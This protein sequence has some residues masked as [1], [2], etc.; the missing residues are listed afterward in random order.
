ME[1]IWQNYDI[2]ICAKYFEIPFLHEKITLK[3]WKAWVKRE[4]EPQNPLNLDLIDSRYV[5]NI[6]NLQHNGKLS[7]TNSFT[8]SR[9]WN[10]FTIW[11]IHRY[12]AG[13]TKSGLR[14]MQNINIKY[15]SKWA[16]TANFYLAELHWFCNVCRTNIDCCS[17]SPYSAKLLFLGI[18]LF[19]TGCATGL[20]YYSQ[21]VFFPKRFLSEP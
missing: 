17:P 3:N 5:L 18:H 6:D 8:V 7:I 11:T 19:C 20:D 21:S 9:T 2:W 12:L 4:V 16:F 10:I 13:W 15:Y 14:C 1:E